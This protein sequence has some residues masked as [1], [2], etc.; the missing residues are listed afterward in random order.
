MS[1]KMTIAFLVIY[2]VSRSWRAIKSVSLL[3]S[4][5][6]IINRLYFDLLI[7]FRSKRSLILRKY[8]SYPCRPLTGC[9]SMKS[10]AVLLFLS[11]LNFRSQIVLFSKESSNRRTFGI[12]C[13]TST[14][15]ARKNVDK[16]IFAP[17]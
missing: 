6:V 13:S 17:E 5:A 12:T 16:S 8:A 3:T 4:S 9:D 7:L 14:D 1:V 15:S 10:L 2:C 11:W